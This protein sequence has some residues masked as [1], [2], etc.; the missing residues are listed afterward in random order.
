VL[1]G[2]DVEDTAE[3]KEG[4]ARARE[5]VDR[6]SMPGWPEDAVQ[7]PSLHPEYAEILVCAGIHAI[8]VNLDVADEV[9]RLVAAAE[10]SAC[11]SRDSCRESAH[12]RTVT[13]RNASLRRRSTRAAGNDAV[14]SGGARASFG[15][16]VRADAEASASVSRR[17]SP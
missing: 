17:P 15:D 14:Q 13:G 9:R 4:T 5:L 16:G 11:C 12:R 6:E 1:E 10:S 8:S 7:A 3:L 2:I